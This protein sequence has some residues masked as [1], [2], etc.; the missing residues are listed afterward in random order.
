MLASHVALFAIRRAPLFRKGLRLR[1]PSCYRL[2]LTVHGN[3]HLSPLSVS[4]RNCAKCLEHFL[5]V[6][7][8]SALLISGPVSA[9]GQAH[10]L[11]AKA[12][13]PPA[14]EIWL[15]G[16]VNESNGEW[17]YLKGKAHLETSEMQISADEIEYNSDTAWAYAHGHVQ[18]EQFSTGDKLNADHGE[19]NLQT[20]EGKFWVVDGTTPAKILTSPGILTTTQPF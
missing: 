12:D 8:F 14:D 3:P 10:T 6:L 1:R 17:R 20:E 7:F 13:L 11:P 18:M 16:I 2:R 5:K 4:S 19:Y 9:Y 15:H